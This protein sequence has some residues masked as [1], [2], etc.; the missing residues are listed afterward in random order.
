MVGVKTDYSRKAERIITYLFPPALIIVNYLVFNF[1]ANLNG[2]K[3]GYLA[4]MIFY[5]LLWCII[6][7]FLLIS[8][9]NRKLLLKIKRL[10]WWQALLLIIPIAVAIIYGPFKSRIADATPIFII[11][12]LLF[13]LV[14]AFCE[15]F[16]WRGLFF[17]HHPS[18]FFYAVIVPTI[19]FGIWYYV[20]LSVH[21]SSIGNFHFIL[22]AIGLGLC[23]A[24]VTY[25]TRSVFWSI[26]SHTLVDLTG[27]G[28]LYFFR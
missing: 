27:L 19:W 22:G 24:I 2:D 8:K 18:N 7:V 13:A 10:N 23:W 11:L 3:K 9:S 15:E 21:P 17:D 6:P 26:V 16:L 5:W 4:G 20:P 14:N 25:Y 28:A 12:S 1:F